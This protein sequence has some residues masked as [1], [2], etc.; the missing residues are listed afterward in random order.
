MS[1]R[2]DRVTKGLEFNSYQH[3]LDQVHQTKV[4]LVLGLTNAH[5]QIVAVIFSCYPNK[6]LQYTNSLIP[7]SLCY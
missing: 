1:G 4:F 5:H 3:I 6:N 2:L 7:L